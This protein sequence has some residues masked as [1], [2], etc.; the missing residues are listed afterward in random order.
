MLSS[1]LRNKRITFLTAECQPYLNSTVASSL[2]P[3]LYYNCINGFGWLG[4]CPPKTIFDPSFNYKKCANEMCRGTGESGPGS[5]NGVWSKWT[6][7]GECFPACG[8][9]TRNRTRTCITHLSSNDV[10]SCKGES[11]ETEQCSDGPC[12]SKGNPAF[13]VTLTEKSEL[14]VGKI[15]WTLVN[16][17]SGG[18]FNIENNSLSITTPGLFMLSMV[19]T[20]GNKQPV[21]TLLKGA[22]QDLG[23]SK[24]PFALETITRASLHVFSPTYSPYLSQSIPT[25]AYSS[26]NGRETSWLG[27]RYNTDSYISLVSASNLK[28][29]IISWPKPLLMKGFREKSDLTE[30]QALSG[31]LYFFSIGMK[32]NNN[33]NRNSEFT[34]IKLYLSKYKPPNTYKT[35]KVEISTKSKGSQFSR[36]F[37]QRI[38]KGDVLITKTYKN[39]LNSS[40]YL[41]NYLLAFK[42][43][44]DFPYFM[45]ARKFSTCEE[46]KNIQFTSIY[47]DSMQS[48]NR[49]KHYYRVKRTGI[50]YIETSFEPKK[51]NSLDVRMYLNDK[52]VGISKGHREWKDETL[53]TKSILLNLNKNDTIRWEN[54]GCLGYYLNESTLTIIYVS[55]IE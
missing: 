37:L 4:Q 43:N 29:L 12:A 44:E 39:F 51:D 45:A 24:P 25:T 28:G 34:D 18:L 35:L 9:G 5:I 6:D 33:E 19:F 48:W 20:C 30:F 46:F 14:D 7:W 8:K 52:I 2:S 21:G 3:S 38:D 31:G 13:M 49:T 17:N 15:N 11:T 26:E 41:E 22:E 23:L 53:L 42:L 16:F 50:Y 36:S 47:F 54:Y 1:F 27:F 55:E 32:A 10:R 40:I